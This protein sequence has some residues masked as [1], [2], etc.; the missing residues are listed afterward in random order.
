MGENRDLDSQGLDPDALDRAEAALSRLSERFVQ[1][2][3]ADGLRLAEALAALNFTQ[4]FTIAHD[5]KGQGTTFGY[6]L[7]TDLANRLCRLIEDNPS[8]DAAVLAGMARLVEALRH[9][10]AERM[11]GDGG[12]AGKRLL[13][14]L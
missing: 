11:T 3:E 12:E 4:T 10:I 7:V 2:A 13:A 5:M 6:P 8:P 9:V 14:D 1:W